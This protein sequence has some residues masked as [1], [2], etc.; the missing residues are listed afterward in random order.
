MADTGPVC[1]KIK[2]AEI[3]PDYSSFKK[4]DTGP[5]YPRVKK[6]EEIPVY[7]RIKKRQTKNPVCTRVKKSR[8]K[9]CLDQSQKHERRPDLLVSK[10]VGTGPVYPRINKANAVQFYTWS[11]KTK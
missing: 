1:P 2:K 7:T 5:V 9:T 10:N 3:E 8:K 11:K 6:A 4:T